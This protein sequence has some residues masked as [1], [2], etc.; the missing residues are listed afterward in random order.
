MP[1]PRRPRAIVK[2]MAEMSVTRGTKRLRANHAMSLIRLLGNCAL[3]DGLEK[4]RPARPRVVFCFRTK[5]R[6]ITTDAVIRTDRLLV[7]LAT[8]E[9]R[10]G[11]GAARDLI[12]VVAQLLTP[13]F[14]ASS[15]FLFACHSDFSIFRFVSRSR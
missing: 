6:C 13:F 1:F 8:R 11:S 5:E 10:L 12:F 14:I 7:P 3:I 9:S 15:N 4:T 2:H